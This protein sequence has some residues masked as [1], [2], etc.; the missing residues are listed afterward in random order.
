MPN[1]CWLVQTRHLDRVRGGMGVPLLMQ[2]DISARVYHTRKDALEA[3][4]NLLPQFR[5]GAKIV[6][7]RIVYESLEDAPR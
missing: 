2:N 3:R 4:E 1:H 6:K 5:K 7:A